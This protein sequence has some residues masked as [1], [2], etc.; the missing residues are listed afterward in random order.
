MSTQPIRRPVTRAKNATQHP[1]QV[2]LDAQAKR[3]TAMEMKKVR[4]EERIDRELTEKGI[5][6]ALKYVA[7][8]Q[9]QQHE[10]DVDAQ[11]PVVAPS[12]RRRKTVIMPKCRLGGLQAGPGPTGDDI[13]ESEQDA[14]MML[15]EGEGDTEV[16]DWCK[17]QA[18]DSPS[19]EEMDIDEGDQEAVDEVQ[20]Q[21]PRRF[22]K[23][24]GDGLPALI[25]AMRKH[26]RLPPGNLKT[27]NVGLVSKA[28][29]TPAR[30]G[31]KARAL[32]VVTSDSQVYVILMHTFFFVFDPSY[33][34][35]RGTITPLHMV[36]CLSESTLFYHLL[37]ASVSHPTSAKYGTGLIANWADHVSSAATALR[38]PAGT[39]LASSTTL[40]SSEFLTTGASTDSHGVAI[41][42]PRGL[43]LDHEDEILAYLDSEHEPSPAKR[44][45]FF[46]ITPITVISHSLDPIRRL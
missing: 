24:K 38:N 42:H 17:D 28:A 41:Y 35:T 34:H 36:N 45:S 3:R 18:E 7:S 11:R 29:P 9:D 39:G 43:E 1:G 23:K 8:I 15:L 26:P 6:A 21:G 30:K 44:V 46:S 19:E 16:D 25:D 13:P 37:R 31:K 20:D 14:D 12:L 33:T 2:V 22:K 32:C 40:S 27:P 10:D 5:R 4:A